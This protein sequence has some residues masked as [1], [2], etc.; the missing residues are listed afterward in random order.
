VASQEELKVESVLALFGEEEK[1]GYGEEQEEKDRVCMIIKTILK[2]VLS[3][4]FS[5][6]SS[7][8]FSFYFFSV[9]G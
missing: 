3:P 2:I 1:N 5:L 4:P 9:E 8:L 7:Y 6:F